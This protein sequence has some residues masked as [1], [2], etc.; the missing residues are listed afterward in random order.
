[1][2]FETTSVH[3]LKEMA[4]RARARVATMAKQAEKSIDAALTVAEVGG[5]AFG[6]GYVNGRYGAIPAGATA[7]ALPEYDVMGVPLDLVS[8]IA[9]VGLGLVG[10]AGKY[11]EH[12]VRIGAGGL[13][14][15]GYR[16]GYQMGAT[17]YTNSSGAN[18]R[19][20]T[21]T[22]G[23]GNG[24]EM[25]QGGVRMRTGERETVRRAA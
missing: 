19:T 21:V 17:A 14:A 5:T 18:S 10:A 15:W 23:R 12:A 9:L 3:K 8:G 1:M 16:T 11:E 22:Q 2:A 20:T 24:G 6:F 7:N 25:G 4:E 13:A